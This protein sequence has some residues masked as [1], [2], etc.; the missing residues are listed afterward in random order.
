MIQ[1]S[2]AGNRNGTNYNTYFDMG[3]VRKGG[4]WAETAQGVS[5]TASMFLAIT[6]SSLDTVGTFTSGVKSTEVFYL[7]K[8]INTAL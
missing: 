3:L 5:K 2:I 7:S 4:D 8:S 6:Y 1:Y